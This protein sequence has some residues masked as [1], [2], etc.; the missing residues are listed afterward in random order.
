[1][2]SDAA[3]ATLFNSLPDD[4][5]ERTRPTSELAALATVAE[6]TASGSFVLFWMHNACRVDDN[7][8]LN[9]AVELANRVGMPLLV[10]H[11]ISERY[12]F[13]SDRHHTFMMQGARDVAGQFDRVGIPYAFHLERPADDRP[14]LRTLADRAAAVDRRRAD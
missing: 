14:H 13:A 12:P 3:A 10:Y 8:A 7:P 6:A 11:A 5:R 9:A 2:P 4:L 1:M